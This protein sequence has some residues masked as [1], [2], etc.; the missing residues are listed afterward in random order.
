VAEPGAFFRCPECK[1]LLGELVEDVFSCECGLRW[2]I[3]N[4]IYNFKQPLE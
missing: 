2:G 4:G 3:E 1:Q